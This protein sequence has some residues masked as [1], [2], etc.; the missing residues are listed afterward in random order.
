[1][2]PSPCR[3]G[4]DNNLPLDVTLAPLQD[5]A[6]NVGWLV[7]VQPASVEVVNR[8]IID[9]GHAQ[10]ALLDIFANEHLLDRGAQ[11]ARVDFQP[12]LLVGDGNLEQ[13]IDVVERN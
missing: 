12:T 7:V 8:R 10:L 4:A 5:E 9:H 13:A 11:S 1:M 6:Q 2:G 3:V